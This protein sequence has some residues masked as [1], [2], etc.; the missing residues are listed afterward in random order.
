MIHS[1]NDEGLL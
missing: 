1:L